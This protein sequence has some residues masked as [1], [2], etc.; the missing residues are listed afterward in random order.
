MS[1]QARLIEAAF[2]PPTPSASEAGIP[3]R[4]MMGRL[5]DNPLRALP[6]SAFREPVVRIRLPGRSL[7][8]VSAPAM[9][10]EVVEDRDGFYA[11]SR[12][13]AALLS[14]LAGTDGA[15]AEQ[16]L[17]PLF[18]PAS[19]VR[20]SARLAEYLEEG[21]RDLGRRELTVD[22]ASLARRIVFTLLL[23]LMG[24]SDLAARRDEI[25]ALFLPLMQVFDRASRLD[26]LP[27]PRFLAPRGAARQRAQALVAVLESLT[28]AR[29]GAVERDG[30]MAG[31][32]DELP[33]S[34]AARNLA[35]VLAIVCDTAA[36]ALVWTTYLLSLFPAVAERVGEELRWIDLRDPRLVA[37]T[38]GL[39]AS[40]VFAESLRL[41]PPVPLLVFDSLVDHS[42]GGHEIDRGD[43]VVVSPWIL[44]RHRRLWRMPDL[45]DPRRFEGLGAEPVHPH[46]WLPF[47]DGPAAYMAGH[48]AELFTRLTLRALLRRFRI[49][50][51]DTHGVMPEIRGSLR[52]RGGLML[53]FI[54]RG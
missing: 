16:R 25:A 26:L 51:D 12:L 8:Y 45:F 3:L 5:W 22:F 7:H 23:D 33:P 54:P 48:A 39:A 30:L 50:P 17:A 31:F 28:A 46:A 32:L 36:S 14:P 47:G 41:Y 40:R 6:A 35:L 38:G 19:L 29:T 10:E 34:D 53:R 44:H 49:A 18:A 9:V 43:K 42:L 52:P 1:Y 20:H 11:P 27:L 15:F 4:E 2:V 24:G 21:V 37:R 13:R